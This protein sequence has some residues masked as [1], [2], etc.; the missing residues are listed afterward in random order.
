MSCG[1]GGASVVKCREGS[2]VRQFRRDV[3]SSNLLV[4]AR[5]RLG[6]AMFVF[7]ILSDLD[8]SPRRVSGV[9]R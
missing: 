4:A 5:D 9:C 7:D 3:S 6:S 8:I 1:L 2:S